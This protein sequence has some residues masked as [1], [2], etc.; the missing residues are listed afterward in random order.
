VPGYVPP[1]ASAWEYVIVTR[2]VGD[3]SWGV[4]GNTSV[5]LDSETVYEILE[6]LGADRYELAAADA[7]GDRYFFKRPK[8]D[9]TLL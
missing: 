7:A 4:V 9:V 8:P 2:N 5:T 3:G 6:L 1:M